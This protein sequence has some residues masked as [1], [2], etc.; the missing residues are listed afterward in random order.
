MAGPRTDHLPTQIQQMMVLH[1]PSMP[2]AGDRAR[3]LSRWSDRSG[4]QAAGPTCHLL[5]VGNCF[6]ISYSGVL[7]RFFYVRRGT[8]QSNCLLLSRSR[9]LVENKRLICGERKTLLT[10]KW[11]KANSTGCGTLMPSDTRS[12]LLSSLYVFP[13]KEHGPGKKVGQCLTA[14]SSCVLLFDL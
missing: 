12:P 8:V 5:R 10:S 9:C 4:P 6:R 14:S 11:L 13:G 2:C 1:M 7:H 3:C